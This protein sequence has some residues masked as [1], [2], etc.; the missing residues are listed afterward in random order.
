MK[1]KIITLAA[2]AISSLLSINA[3]RYVGGDISLLPD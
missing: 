2:F 3:E 1:Y